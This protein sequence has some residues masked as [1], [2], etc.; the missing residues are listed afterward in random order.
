MSNG[1]WHQEAI[2]TLIYVVFETHLDITYAIHV[3]SK[4]SKNPGID[5][6]NIT[7]WVFLLLSQEYMRVL[8]DL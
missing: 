8:V 6:R 3:L 4:F 2:G 7:K 5:H 1:M